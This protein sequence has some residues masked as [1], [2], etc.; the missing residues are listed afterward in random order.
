MHPEDL[1]EIIELEEEIDEL[2]TKM[3][4]AKDWEEFK[5]YREM[6]LFNINMI[7]GL[8]KRS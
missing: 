8:Q 1:P 4:K 6:A 3:R 5:M 2:I 7:R